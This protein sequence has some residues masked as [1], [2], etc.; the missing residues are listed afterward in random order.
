[1]PLLST[2]PAISLSLL[3]VFLCLVSLVSLYN[4]RRLFLE[5]VGRSH[6]LA[7]LLHFGCIIFGALA[8]VSPPNHHHHHHQLLGDD[9]NIDSSDRDTSEWRVWSY[10]CLL[11]DICLGVL[12]TAATLT[13]ARS[14]PH[15]TIS[16]APGQSG[17]LSQ[18]AYVTQDEM[19]EH[20]FYQVLNLVQV[21]YLHGVTW[22]WNMP[23]LEQ[24][25]QPQLVLVSSMLGTKGGN[26]EQ[27]LSSI[28]AIVLRLMAV[29]AATSPW[30]LRHYFPVHS[31][32]AN[33][34]KKG[35]TRGKQ[36]QQQETATEWLE[37]RLYQIKKWQYLFYK[38]VILHGLNLSVAFPAA[39]AAASLSPMPPLTLTMPWRIFWICLN[40]SYVMEF[41]LQSLVK[42]EFLS[43]QSMLILQRVLMTASSVSAM[44]AVAN[45][46]RPEFCIMSVVL[47][48][49]N[50]G[51]D[52]LNV[53]LVAVLAALRI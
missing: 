6:R 32:S 7:G 5:P 19:I 37:T 51:R 49:T 47:N 20:S 24:Q 9:G 29:L 48:F 41:Y 23:S 13:A 36:Y 50:R 27:L 2:L 42:R 30:L 46:V 38:H 12:G 18:K 14:F 16:N 34:I 28:R 21:M 39:S 35:L 53:M 22:L 10:K 40:A 31:F 52:V 8:V 4:A 11:Y 15:R 44:L 26:Q 33:W 45:V 43:Q 1:M 25:Q 17:T 3:R